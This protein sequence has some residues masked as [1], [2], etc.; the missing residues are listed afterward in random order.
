MTLLGIIPAKGKSNRLPDKN[1]TQC[2]G[3]SLVQRAIETAMAAEI[4]DK[5]VLSSEDSR[6]LE[7][8]EHFGVEIRARRP[9]LSEDGVTVAAVVTDILSAYE[10]QPPVF[11][12][13]WPTSPVRTPQ[14]LRTIWGFVRTKHWLSVHTVAKESAVHDG[15]A[16]FM[17]TRHFL[18]RLSLDI[19]ARPDERCVWWTSEDAESLDVNTPD[20][21]AEAERRL[22][23]R[24]A[25]VG[26]YKI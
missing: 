16:L 26:G 23:L 3:K 22:L 12:V 14:T 24:E 13:L 17:Q 4:F 21:L 15:V 20:D 10:Y 1:L 11:C 8:G 19:D 6:I 18:S 7:I 25:C 9:I 5:I 2:A